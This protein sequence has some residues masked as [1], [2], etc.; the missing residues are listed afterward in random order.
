MAL[1]QQMRVFGGVK[2]FGFR[3]WDLVLGVEGFGFRVSDFVLW[4]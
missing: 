3:V 1:T 2:G 4:A